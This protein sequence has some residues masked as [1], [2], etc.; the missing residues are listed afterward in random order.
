[1]IDELSFEEEVM[2]IAMWMLNGRERIIVQGKLGYNFVFCYNLL[3]EITGLEKKYKTSAFGF[4]K[5]VQLWENRLIS[6]S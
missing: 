5:M 1:M 2:P 3:G 4:C 6:V